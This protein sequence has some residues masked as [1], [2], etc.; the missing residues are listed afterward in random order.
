MSRAQPASVRPSLPVPAAPL[1]PGDGV[2]V[3]WV[4]HTKPRCEKKFQELCVAEQW[5]HFLP[6]RHQLRTY[7][8]RKRHSTVP[9]FNGYVFGRIAP[10]MKPRAFARDHL[11]RMI[12]VQNET[13]FL[14][15]VEQIR[16]LIASGVEIEVAPKLIR[17]VNV[18]VKS[19]PFMGM[20][21]QVEDPDRATRI[22]ISLDV[23]QQAVRV[24]IDADQLEC[25]D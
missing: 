11:V 18:R 16:R 10:E 5:V 25:L 4:C 20:V 22:I 2:Q 13:L 17:G 7:G 14:E 1:P 9:L 15:Q 24:Q 21:G 3:W 23:L 12:R 6:L 8:A 19:G